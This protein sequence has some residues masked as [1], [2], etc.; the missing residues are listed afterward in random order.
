VRALLRWA[1][2]HRLPVAAGV[3]AVVLAV[4]LTVLL[5]PRP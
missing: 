4:D 1:V 5:A 2:A 3:T